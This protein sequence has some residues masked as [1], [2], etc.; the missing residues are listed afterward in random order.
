MKSSISQVSSQRGA[1]ISVQ[2]GTPCHFSLYLG[3]D[4]GRHGKQRKPRAQ[5]TFGPSLTRTFS[6]INTR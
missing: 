5:M 1:W 3:S 4:N 2:F 6:L